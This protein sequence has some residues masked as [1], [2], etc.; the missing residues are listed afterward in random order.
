VF[1]SG[2]GK[3]LEATGYLDEGQPG[4]GVLIDEAARASRRGRRFAPDALW[5]GP[6]ALTVYFKYED[7]PPPLEDV[8]AWRQE[9]WNEGFAPLLWVI[10]PKRIDLYNG[11]GRPQ[12]EGD[13]TANLLR[14]FEAVDQELREL[15]ELAGRFAMET[16]QFWLRTHS[17]NRKTSVDQQL[18]SDLAALEQDL[19]REGLDRASAQGLIGRSIFTQYLI[20]RKIVDERRLMR[21]CGQRTLSAALRLS[22]A[23]DDLFRWLRD[24]FNGDMFPASMSVQRIRHK[25]FSR[26]AD[27]LE[28]S[29][30][31]TGQRSFF[32]YQFEVIPVELI[33]SI[34]EQFAHSKVNEQDTGQ[35][36][37]TLPSSTA[38]SQGVH[39]T[40]LPLVSLILDE[41]MDG[42]TGDETVLDLTCGS[43]V[44]LV[45]AFRRLV[46][47][48]GGAQPSRQMIRST[49]YRQIYGVDISEA[50]IRV[51]AF[52]LYLAALEL[53]PNP[54]PPEALKFKPLIKHTLIVGDARDVENTPNG[55]PLRTKDKGRRRFDAI[56]GN[57]PWTFKGKRGTE[58]RRRRQTLGQAMQPRGEGLDFV[59]RATD[60]GHD[61]TRYGIVLSAMPFFAGSKTGAAAALNVIQKLSPAAL[62]NLAPLIRWLFPTAKMPAVALLARCRQQPSDQLT[63]VNVPWSPS[64]ERSQTFEIAPSDILTLKIGDWERDPKRLKAAAFGRARDMVLLDDLRTR[65]AA[66]DSWLNSVGSE[67]RDGLI[68]GKLPQRTR[69]AKHL[70]NLEFLET[71]DLQPFNVPTGLGLFREPKAQWP[72]ARGTYKSPLLLIKEFLKSGPRPI[73]ALVDRDL[74]YTDAYFGAS[75][76]QEHRQSGY[77]IAAILSSAFASWFFLM[78]AAEFGVW[79]RRLLTNDVGLLPIPNPTSAIQTKAGREILT[80]EKTFRTGGDS[81]EG[82]AN[83][84][85]AVCDLYEL[86]EV[87]RLIVA[88]GLRRA[89]WQWQEGR[90]DAAG[91]ADLNLDLRPYAK[92]FLAGI[93]PWLKA[94]NKRHM[95]AEVFNLPHHA[96][97]RVVRFILEDRAGP[98]SVEVIAPGGDLAALIGR[99]G[100]RLGVRLASSLVGERELR[101]HGPN[102]VIVIKPAA[103]RFWMRISALEDADAVISESFA[104]AAA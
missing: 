78:T 75:L 44:F 16:G 41:V 85:K 39:Y 35:I 68:L 58:D 90:E 3:I 6:S 30:P 92:A 98:S 19:V 51:A 76:G 95:R 53:D 48:K 61:H 67:W 21:H 97:L 50:A 46:M 31:Q 25:H 91:P 34:Y 103:R 66:L 83:L 33:S 24:V 59:L 84:D 69:D 77:L 4:P 49:L 89:A 86:A 8:A 27:F 15:D 82:W 72:R 1:P 104:G 42:L 101:V 32:P 65:F 87:D 7:N 96:P 18:L 11:Y 60:F 93:E 22:S 43:G 45:E 26:V 14:T 79:K 74:V 12:A 94:A 63:V 81:P 10:S 40:R 47:L 70:Y 62:V 52:S 100:Q 5:R 64:G 88:D 102:E 71:G 2:L 36:D 73:T 56:V 17:V 13:A 28:A 55:A 23:A 29:N 99:I 9:I 57:P 80:L 54:R 20:D 38:K 37:G